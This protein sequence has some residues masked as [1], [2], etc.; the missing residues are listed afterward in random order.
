MEVTPFYDNMEVGSESHGPT[1]NTDDIEIDIDIFQDRITEDNDVVVEDAS[2]TASDQPAVAEGPSEPA[3]DADMLDGEDLE[4]GAHGAGYVQYQRDYYQYGDD[5]YDNQNTYGTQME[6]DYVDAK[7]M[8]GFY[9]HL[10]QVLVQI[11]FLDGH[12]EVLDSY[13]G[14]DPRLVFTVPKGMVSYEVRLVN[15]KHE[16]LHFEFISIG[17]IGA[18]ELMSATFASFVGELVRAELLLPELLG[19]LTCLP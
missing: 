17:E 3:N 5:S 16:W 7:E 18:V 14:T 10:E 1:R 13:R 19:P 8:Q 9:E 12:K 2:I 15:L 4:R 6:D 11:D